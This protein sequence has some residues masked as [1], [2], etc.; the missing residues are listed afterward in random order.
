MKGIKVKLANAEKTKKKLAELKIINKSYKIKKDKEQMYIPIKELSNLK[1]FEIINMDFEEIRNKEK[2]L[3]TLLKEKLSKEEIR[4]IKTSFDTVGEI[5]ILEIDEDMRTKEKIIAQTLLETQK[6]IK[7]V[8]RK[9][10]AH[11]GEYR[12]Q[13]MKWLAGENK[14]ETTHKENSVALKVNVETVYFSPR[15]STERKRIANQV[16][17]MN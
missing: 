3:K 6:N 1:D 9:D 4:R 8:L 14:K 16:K 10:E 11:T 17:E 7:T 13:N 12:T 2:N 5:A 15:L